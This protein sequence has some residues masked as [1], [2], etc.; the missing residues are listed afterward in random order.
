M[1][2][3][4]RRHGLQGRSGH[5]GAGEWGEEDGP[6][7]RGL[8]EGGGDAL[9]GGWVGGESSHVRVCEAEQRLELGVRETH[10]RRARLGHLQPSGRETR[11]DDT[12]VRL[13][14]RSPCLSAVPISYQHNDLLLLRSLTVPWLVWTTACVLTQAHTGPRTRKL[15]STP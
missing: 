10:Q 15:L 6:E 5:G 3:E 7:E 14:S 9:G 12:V 1:R 4:G 11:E 13:P 8:G 2:R